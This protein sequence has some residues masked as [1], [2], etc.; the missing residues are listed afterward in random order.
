MASKFRVFRTP[1]LLSPESA[2]QVIRAGVALHNFLMT[3][4]RSTYIEPGDMDSENATHNFVPGRW[5]SDPV[6]S[7]ML[8]VERLVGQRAAN[9]AIA[10]RN[11]FGGI[12]SA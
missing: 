12:F 1:I 4:S 5:E 6:L 7:N 9:P 2:V 11:A 3:K 8:N 10:Q